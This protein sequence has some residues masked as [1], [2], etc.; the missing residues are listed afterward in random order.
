MPRA[1]A[2]AHARTPFLARAHACTQASHKL[3]PIPPC[4]VPRSE[5]IATFG[6]CAWPLFTLKPSINA[7]D[8]YL[9]QPG[10]AGLRFDEAPDMWPLKSEFEFGK[11][12]VNGAGFSKGV[13]E[14]PACVRHAKYTS[15]Y[16]SS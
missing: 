11:Q 10:G 2:V 5:A 1:R 4:F 12:L 14:P 9:T 8:H 6:W 3:L 15:T 7:L 16:T 13:I